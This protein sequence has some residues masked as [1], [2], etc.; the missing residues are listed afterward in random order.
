MK[1]KFSLKEEYKKSWKYI[2]EIRKFI[3]SIIGIFILF[4]LI[5]YFVPPP[6]Y[7]SQ[8]ILAFLE[9]LLNKTRGM[10]YT[11]ITS[12]IFFNNLKSSFF[13]MI[14]GVLFGIFPII[15][16]IMN[17]YVLGFVAEMSV[18]IQGILILL[19]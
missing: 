15:S 4:S 10:S 9:E 6:E 8:Q 17:G 7:L 14:F 12:Y 1:K 16:T 11:E 19:R 2:K 13:G 18:E 3:Y 5:G